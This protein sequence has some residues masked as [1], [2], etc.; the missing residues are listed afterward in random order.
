VWHFIEI[1]CVG[2]DT[3]GRVTVYV[4]NVQKVNLTGLDTANG[5]TLMNGFAFGNPGTG[6]YGSPPQIDDLHFLDV[7][8]RIGERR[9]E[10]LYAVSDGGTLL[11]VPSTGVNHFA[12][13]D[14]TLV[15]SSDYLSGSAVGDLDLLGLGNLSSTPASIDSLNVI[16]YAQ[17]TDATARAINNGIKS[18]ATS[19]NGADLSLAVGFARRER[20]LF[21]DPDTGIAWTPGAV[22]ALELQPRVAV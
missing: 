3:I 5:T 18:G 19:S 17:K 1:E 4:D 12:V 6:T 11:L 21:V 10:T 14:E 15:A 2:S 22:N 20:Y 16:S 13:V 8:T 7:A 9:N